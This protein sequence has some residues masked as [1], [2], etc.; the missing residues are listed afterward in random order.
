[1]SRSEVRTAASWRAFDR[2]AG[3]IVPLL[4]AV[5]LVGL[6]W[7]GRGPE[8]AG[9]CCTTER[10]HVEAP[11]PPALTGSAPPN[12]LAAVPVSPPVQTAPP[13][14]NRAAAGPPPAIDCTR[15][16]DGVQIAFASSRA[17]LSPAAREALDSIAQRCL[18]GR[19]YEVGGHTDS[20]GRAAANRRLSLARA[21]AVV[22]YLVSRGLPAPQLQAAGHGDT[23]PIA[24]NASPEGRARN[25]RITFT[26]R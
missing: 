15:L 3:V 14:S 8:V 23:R 26:P 25:R 13:D 2:L 6:W 10:A 16:V 21:Q 7:M 4:L 19:R 18:A 11:P 5:I 1:M 9:T 20:S 12:T 17:T 22:N 24:D